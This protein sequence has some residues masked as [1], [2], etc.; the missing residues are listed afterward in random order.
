MSVVLNNSDCQP[1]P[2]GDARGSEQLT[3]WPVP[4]DGTER[5][6]QRPKWHH[7]TS[8]R[9]REAARDSEPRQG[10]RKADVL[11]FV[12]SR[13]Q[14]GAT[15]EEISE[16]LPLAIQSVCSPVRKLLDDRLLVETAATRPT[17]QGSPAAVLIA[18]DVLAGET[19]EGRP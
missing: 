15:R 3:L 18:A 14:Q 10:T 11:R 5:R 13:G 12:R 7:R 9:S 2:A 1:L 6:L 16:A 8:P 19:K 4:G 17:R